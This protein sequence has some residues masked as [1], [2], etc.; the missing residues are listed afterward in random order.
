MKLDASTLIPTLTRIP[1]V[2]SNAAGGFDFG[3]NPSGLKKI[4]VECGRVPYTDYENAVKRIWIDF[5]HYSNPTDI[6]DPC[7]ST[8][9]FGTEYIVCTFTPSADDPI[10][11]VSVW[12]DANL[13]HAVQFHTMK[14]SSRM[15]GA[16]QR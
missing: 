1:A 9:V 14:T 6:P 13:I 3:Y 16:D 5:F 8:G 15:Y 7:A 10:V 11:K 4:H 12:S 2:G